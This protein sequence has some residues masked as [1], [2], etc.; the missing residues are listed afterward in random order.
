[1][2]HETFDT[3]IVKVNMDLLKSILKPNKIDKKELNK[4]KVTKKQ[5]D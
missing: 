2:K 4:P 3:L 5:T 1:M